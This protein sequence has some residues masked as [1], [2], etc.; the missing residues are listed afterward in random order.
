MSQQDMESFRQ[1]C[2]GTI[3]DVRH[4]RITQLEIH[5]EIVDKIIETFSDPCHST[6]KMRVF[7]SEEN[8]IIDGHHRAVACILKNQ[9][10]QSCPLFRNVVVCSM[11]IYDCLEKARR[12]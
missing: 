10:T 3:T 2:N 12:L 5:L 1:R 6:D 9:R 4:V 11:N 8:Y 7:L